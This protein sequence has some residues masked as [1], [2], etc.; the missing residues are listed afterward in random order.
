MTDIDTPKEAIRSYYENETKTS[1]WLFVDQSM[2][3]KFGEATRDLDWLHTDPDR[4]KQE[5]PFGGTIAHGFMTMSML[6]Y[7]VRQMQG[8]DYP[9]GTLYGL[10]YGFDRLRLVSPVPVGSRIRCHGRLLDVTDRGD[11]RYLVKTE[12]RIEV[13]GAKKPALVAEWLFMLVYPFA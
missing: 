12:Y 3:T 7:F 6:T 2:V 9:D 4:A 8:Q 5:S 11:N 1:D 13:E 10:N